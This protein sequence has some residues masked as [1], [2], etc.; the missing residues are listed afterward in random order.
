MTQH[1]WI[2]TEPRLVDCIRQLAWL[3]ARG[4]SRP[5]RVL[6]V[7]TILCAGGFAFVLLR[8]PSYAPRYVLRVVETGRDPKDLPRPRRQLAEYVKTGVF[9]SEPLLGLVRRYGLYPSLLRKSPRA[10]LD[11]FREDID[12]DVYRNYFVEERSANSAPRSARVSISYRNSN[13]DVAVA[14]TRD[15]GALIVEHERAMRREQSARAAGAA[16]REVDARRELLE[17]RRFDVAA[18]RAEL[19]RNGGRDPKLEVEFTDL[20]ASTTALALRQDIAERREAELAVG[21]ALEARGLGL[22]FEVV[23][24]ASLPTRSARADMELVLG[25]AS[26]VFGLPLMIVGVG[27]FSPKKGRA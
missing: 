24:D 26:L 14:V 27:A 16:K 10:A 22:S 13:P 23:N 25:G 18:K 19:E 15:L 6:L 7:G 17:A 11:T 9:T 12:I 5:I 2:D 1:N 3:F 20:A 8:T 4:V 21:A